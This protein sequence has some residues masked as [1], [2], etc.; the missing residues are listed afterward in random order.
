M[1]DR[2]EHRRQRELDVHADELNSKESILEDNGPPEV[3]APPNG[4]V[5]LPST[6]VPV[7]NADDE[8]YTFFQSLSRP[9]V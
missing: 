5:K 8:V 1:L 3:I 7:I 6:V 4:L 2:E 9:A